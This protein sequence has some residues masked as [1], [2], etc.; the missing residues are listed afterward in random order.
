MTPTVKQLVELAQESDNYDPID[1]GQLKITE[2]H[3]YEM[4]A[5]NVLEQF[6]GVPEDQRLTVAMATVTKLLVENFV[7]NVKLRSKK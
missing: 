6:T 3:A 5:S 7:L 4:M 1:W 2:D